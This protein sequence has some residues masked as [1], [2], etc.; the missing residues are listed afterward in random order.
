[1]LMFVMPSA[2]QKEIAQLHSS[3]ILHP[4]HGT[5]A[6]RGTHYESQS[7]VDARASAIAVMVDGKIDFV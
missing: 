6:I 2:E 4:R 5:S 3:L 7:V 1:M